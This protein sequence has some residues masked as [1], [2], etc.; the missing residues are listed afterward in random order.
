MKF[1][2]LEIFP[3]EGCSLQDLYSITCGTPKKSFS[4]YFRCSKGGKRNFQFLLDGISLIL[5][6]S[7]YHVY[8]DPF[9]GSNILMEFLKSRREAAKSRWNDKKA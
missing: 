4:S 1:L 8:G 3:Y 6:G 2:C 5:T 7:K 9:S